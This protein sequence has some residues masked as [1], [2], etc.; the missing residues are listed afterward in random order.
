M[1]PVAARLLS[2]STAVPPYVLEQSAVANR[3][4]EAFAHRFPDFKKL[5]Q[6]FENCGIARRHAVQPID[7]YLAHH[8]WPDRTAVYL[9][10]ATDLFVTAA[11]SAIDQA[12]LTSDE[13]DTV[14][15]VSSTGIATPSL[16]ARAAAIL[17][18]AEDVAR[19]PV[20]GLGCAGGVT[21]LSLAARL[22][23]ARPGTNVLVVAVEL[24]TLAVRL[25]K[26]T[27]ANIVALALFGDGAAAA[28]VRAGSEGLAV[29]HHAAEHTWPDTLDIMGWDV[30]PQG[31]GVIFDRSIPD[32]AAENLAP[33]V[34]RIL[35]TQGLNPA[36]V[37]RFICHP[38][39]RKVIEAIEEALQLQ[40]GGLDYER[41][42]LADFGNMSAP[43]ALFVLQR[44][45]ETGLPDN[46]LLMALGP[47]FTLS[48][49]TL[50]KCAA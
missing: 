30:E 49:V 11:R 24:C 47:G 39:G 13:I 26:T 28:V 12:G 50:G 18:F 23:E 36:E 4:H 14:V 10:T 29:I 21:G 44:V 9:K 5:G 34:R 17:G 1:S 3:V 35:K 6:V 40:T 32:F 43:T 20:F 15:T 46:S 37:G 33:A 8:E 45:L 19:V 2:V 22:A 7:W 27:K 41:Q 31:F 42:V 38:G 16:D 48:T 25:D